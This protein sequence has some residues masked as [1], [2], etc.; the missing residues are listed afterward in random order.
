LV[1]ANGSI[2]LVLFVLEYTIGRSST[3]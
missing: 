3:E 1:V 2:L